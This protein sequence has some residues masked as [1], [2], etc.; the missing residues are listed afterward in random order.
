M[1]TLSLIVLVLSFTFTTPITVS[2]VDG[3]YATYDVTA[4]MSML[5]TTVNITDNR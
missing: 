2:N 4:T 5:E 1:K 3:F